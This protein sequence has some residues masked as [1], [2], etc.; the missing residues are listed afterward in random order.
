MRVRAGDRQIV[1]PGQS[2]L[3]AVNPLLMSAHGLGTELGHKEIQ[4]DLADG[5]QAWVLPVGVQGLV[6]LDQMPVSHL[7]DIQ[8]VNAQ[9]VAVTKT[10]RQFPD[11]VEVLWCDRR[12]QTVA[13][14]GRLRPRPDRRQ[15]G[16]ELWRIEVTVGVDPEHGAIMPEARQPTGCK[17]GPNVIPCQATIL[18][19]TPAAKA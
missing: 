11:T 7:G 15:V 6:E 18:T 1:A 10:M 14:P 12:N 5:Q 16:P 9:G 13:H 3:L 2:Q 4:P 19:A 8:G 17:S